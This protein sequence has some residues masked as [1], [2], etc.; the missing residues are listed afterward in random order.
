MKLTPLISLLRFLT[1]VSIALAGRAQTLTVLVNFN[2]AN[3]TAPNAII[4]GTDGN[5]YGTTF[6]GGAVG[7]GTVFKMT[8]SGTLTTLYSFSGPDGGG[9][10][11]PLSAG[12]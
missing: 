10:G 12:A 8:P 6:I 1:L 9:P 2:G 5:F 7:P 11:G 3:G 4:Q